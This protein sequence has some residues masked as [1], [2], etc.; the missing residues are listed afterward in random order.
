MNQ[1]KIILYKNYFLEKEHL[2]LENGS[3]KV[4]LFRY[5]TGVE[6]IKVCNTKGYIVMLPNQ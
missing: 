3:L 1:N 5:E 4:S 6:A 2:F